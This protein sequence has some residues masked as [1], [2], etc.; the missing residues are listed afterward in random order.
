M[1]FGKP[2]TTETLSKNNDWF[3]VPEEVPTM[4]SG[5]D[6]DVAMKLRLKLLHCIPV[7]EGVNV[8]DLLEVPAVTETDFDPIPPGSF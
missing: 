6:D 7:P 1:S 4:L 3:P 2:G 5:V 8:N